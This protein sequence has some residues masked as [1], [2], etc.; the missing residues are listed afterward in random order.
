MERKI[1]IEKRSFNQEE[2]KFYKGKIY[3]QTKNRSY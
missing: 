1:E 2:K 3:R